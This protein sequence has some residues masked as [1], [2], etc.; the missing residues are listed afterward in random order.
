MRS[1]AIPETDLRRWY[2]ELEQT[3]Y[4][5]AAIYACSQ[6]T[7]RN[8]LLKYGIPMRSNA[9]AQR[10]RNRD[11]KKRNQGRAGEQNPN[12]RHGRY[13]DERYA[14]RILDREFCAWCDAR[15]K[16]VIHHKNGDH[17]DNRRENLEVV[18]R[19][20]HQSYHK[21]EWWANNH[22]RSVSQYVA[23]AKQI[24]T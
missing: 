7:V 19:S 24:G 13:I 22:R 17:F 21:T 2:L 6:A 12:Y 14:H 4:Q 16:L 11:P 23:Q 10:L 15:D 1:I 3:Q 18:C 8:Y 5:I 20:C 9:A